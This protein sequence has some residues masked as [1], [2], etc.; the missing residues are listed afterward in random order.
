MK[1]HAWVDRSN[2]C[3]TNGNVMKTLLLAAVCLAAVPSFAEVA[4]AQ[5]VTVPS[6]A[7]L[8]DSVKGAVV[9]LDVA[10]RASEE[11]KEALERFFKRR[12]ERPRGEEA[13]LNQGSGSGFII[14]PRGLVLT[15]NH[16]VDGAITI[17][18]RLDDGRSFDG[19]V[20]G[21][22]PLTD[23]A[24][25]KLNG[26]FD[27]LP[28]VKLG[29]SSAMKVGDWVVAIGAPYGLAQSVSAGIISAS[30]RQIGASRYD[31]FLQTDAA[32]NPGNSG[33]P[34]FNL[35]GEVIG[36]NTAIIGA[37]TGIGFAVPANLIKAVVP[38]LEKSGSVTRGWLGVGIQDVSPAL[39]KALS[40]PG[41]DGALITQVND[42]SPAAKGGVKTEDVV[43]AIDGEHVGSSSALTRTV[44]L[45][46]P[47]ATVTLAVIRGGKPIELKVKLGVR[48]DLENLGDTSAK[49]TPAPD[50]HRLGLSFQDIDPRLAEQSGLPKNG[51]LVI[52]VAPG[53]PAD[54]ASFHRGMTVV[55]LNR[56]PVKS[57]D[58][59][60]SALK[61]LQPGSVA[62]F[63][64][65]LPGSSSNTLIALEV[66]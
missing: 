28:S 51:A 48:P 20:L 8:I 4:P 52:E 29:D 10:R 59:L 25:V 60:M 22:D 46:R 55:E 15:N 47:D 41:K 18:V 42:G 36:M 6:L 3:V 23:V 35:R 37:A 63:R 49:Q 40:V 19:T 54:E 39:A 31:Q 7:P 5:T 17:K 43:L 61:T 64:V 11:Q 14:D 21:R 56:K 13:P 16:V 33:G 38:Q 26:K 34:L 65:A 12:G 62:L 53:S 24:L 44:A 9:N 27:A 2:P 66:P 50:S 30:D 58:E 57:R 1:S 45:K 32:I